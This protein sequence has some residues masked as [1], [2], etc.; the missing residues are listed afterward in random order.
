M[1]SEAERCEDCVHSKPHPKME[2]WLLCAQK[3]QYI[4]L[5]APLAVCTFDPTRFQAK[6]KA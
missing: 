4:Y 6:V 5:S 1:A 2:G 3:P